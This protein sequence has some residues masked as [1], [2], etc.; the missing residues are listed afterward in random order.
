[1]AWPLIALALVLVFVGLILVVARRY[2]RCPSNKILIIYGRTSSGRASRALHGGG[3]FVWPLLQ[4]YDFLSLDPVQIEIPLQGALSIENIRVSV[5]S[6]FTVAVG[7]DAETMNNASVRLLGLDTREIIKQAE[8]I[9]FGQL[10]QV[11]ASMKIEEINRDRDVFLEKIQMSLEPELKKIGL[12]LI[13]VNIKD[14]TDESGYIEAIGRKAAAE[15]IQQATIDVSQQEKKGAIGVANA[16]RERAVEVA[17]AAR[18]RDIGTTEAERDRAIKVADLTRERTVGEKA[19]E[20]EREAAIKDSER[21]MRIRVAEANAIAVEGENSSKAKI[22][23]TNASLRVREAAAY[24]E[25]ESRY[26][27]A[28]AAVKEAQYRAEAKT[29]LAQAEKIEAEKRAELEAVSKAEKAMT[30][31]DAEANAQR[32]RIEAEGEAAAIFAK[33]Q[34]EA[35]GQYEILAQKGEGLRRIVDACGDSQSAFQMLM[36]EHLDKLAETAATAIA[37]IKFDKIVVWD[38]GGKDGGAGATSGFLR[39]LAGSLPPMMHMMKDIGGVEL[40]EYF[41]KFAAGNKEADAGSGDEP[42]ATD[43]TVGTDDSASQ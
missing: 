4:S 27:E 12:V 39:N 14:I 26:R 43:S 3:A 38:G 34:A 37:N 6:V 2:K 21:E 40:P 16:E 31:V 13:N 42:S 11:I 1:M 23:E 32:R 19:A 10:R 15:A 33:L 8:D 24:L 35:K 29:A 18:E 5:P 28:E 17:I 41:A 25:G 22:A 30:I 9:I 7:I 20:F 36:L